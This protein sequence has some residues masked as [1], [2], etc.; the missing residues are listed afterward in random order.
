MATLVDTHFLCSDA[1]R[2]DHSSLSLSLSLSLTHLH[3]V[4]YVLRRNFPK[5]LKR[6]WCN[7]VT[8]K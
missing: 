1:E 3:V 2:D 5:V 7:R 4:S 8:K 6:C